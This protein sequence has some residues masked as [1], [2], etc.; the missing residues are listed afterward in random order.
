MTTTTKTIYRAVDPNGGIHKRKSHRVYTHTVV[1]QYAEAYAIQN[2]KHPSWKA[3]DA[4]NFDHYQK[5]L[6]AQRPHYWSEAQFAATQAKARE[7]IA[8]CSTPEEYHTKKEAERLADIARYAA[9][10]YYERW[11]NAGFCGSHGLAVKLASQTSGLGTRNVTI[12]P[13]EAS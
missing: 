2:A 13:V 4:R 3:T 6:T 1:F 11:Q 8:G 9:E 12:L 5:T 7:Y 10:G